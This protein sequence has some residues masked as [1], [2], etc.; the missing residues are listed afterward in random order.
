MFKATEG[1]VLPTTMTGS[2]PKPNWYTQGLRGRAFKTALGDTLFREQY[3]DAVA[4]VITDQE[5]AGLDILTDGD[6]RFDLEVGGK[7]WFFYVL[8]RMGGL[9]GSKSQSPGWSG[10]F[11]IKPGHI[12]YEVQEAYQSPIVT[13]KLTGGQLDYSALWKVA[14]KMTPNTV[15]F[16]TISSQ[17]LTRMM[18]NEFYPTDKELI[19]DCCDIINQELRELAAAGCK[20][21]QIEEPRH[22]FM[23]QDPATKDEDYAFF[24][25]AFNREVK[26]VDAEIWLHTC[27]GNPAQ[28]RLVTN[29]TYEKAIPHLLEVNADVITFECAG[30]GGK[31]LPLF[32]GLETTKK[33]A[34]GVVNHTNTVVESP[35]EVAS[36]IRR[37][38]EFVPPERLI[39]STDCGF[40][41]EGISRRIA[42]HKCVSLVLGT[43]IVRK[44]LGL[45]EATVRAADPQFA[46]TGPDGS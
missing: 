45:P 26:D 37:A 25:E 20:L 21:I 38:L 29:P 23:A 11:G 46:F 6:S 9:Q 22:H 40:G 35:N 27:W 17:S 44:E 39:I 42:Y 10:D 15:K 16:G 34:I 13:G 24:T 33:F 30:A 14:Q 7:S 4:T 5:M 32:A 12:L 28:Q 31:D 43:N 3:L 36:L 2:Y 19:L 41:R 1:M 8:E 18:W